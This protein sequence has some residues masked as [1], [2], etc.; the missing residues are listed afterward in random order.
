MFTVAL[1][2]PESDAEP[3]RLS[4]LLLYFLRLGAFG[5]GG[6]IALSAAMR[7]DLVEAR[8]WITDTEYREGLALAQVAPGPLAAQ[9][10]IYLGWV[11]FGVFGP[12]LS[13]W[14][15]SRLYSLWCSRSRQPTSA[16]VDCRGCRARFT[17]SEQS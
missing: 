5:F 10:A 16:S 4:A 7:R 14:P 12:R 8:G 6:P 13:R 17:E 15:S 1:S 3:V 2:R 9:L 11:R